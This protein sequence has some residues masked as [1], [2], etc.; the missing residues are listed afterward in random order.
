MKNIDTGISGLPLSKKKKKPLHKYIAE[1]KTFRHHNPIFL[2]PKVTGPSA[3]QRGLM[4]Y[5]LWHLL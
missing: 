5:W 3:V 4:I 2:T 1:P